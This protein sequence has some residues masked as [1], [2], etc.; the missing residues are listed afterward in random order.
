MMALRRGF[1]AE[2]GALAHEVRIEIELGPLD[3][4]VPSELAA[5][6]DIPVITLSDLLTTLP[7]ARHFLFVER[8][9]FS[10]PT[11]FGGHR[12]K[13]LHNDSHSQVRQNSNLVHELAH[14]LLR[15][16]PRPALDSRTRCRHWNDTNEHE[17][18]WLSGE[19]LVTSD[20]AL[21]IARGRLTAHQARQRLGVSEAM[22]KWRINMVGADKRVERER[23]AHRTNSTHTSVLPFSHS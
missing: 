18:A 19:L 5:H 22:L 21:T 6:L 12:R 23:A 9:A 11:V 15:Y 2:A 13:I 7:S 10:T 17:A 20:M 16:E 1:K 4:L 3:R 8:N 14:A